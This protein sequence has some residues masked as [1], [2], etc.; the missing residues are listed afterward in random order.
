MSPLHAASTVAG[1][2]LAVGPFSQIQV[3]GHAEVVLVQGDRETVT[4]EG[5]S[6]DPAHIRVRSNNGRLRIDAESDHGWF[7]LSGRVPTI[8]V[9]FR[10]LDAL[11]MS[12][13]VKVSA[14]AIDTPTLKVSAAGAAS[15]KIDQ[16]KTSELRFTGAGAAKSEIGGSATTQQIVISG[17]GSYRAAKLVSD[18]VKAIVS[19]AGR[20]VVNAQKDLS[21]T[22]S[23]AGAIDYLGDPAVKQR[24]SGAG[25]ITRRSAEAIPTQR[26]TQFVA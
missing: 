3:S 6:N 13:T 26:R 17:V 20:V 18:S 15:L 5:S 21:A 16:L 25:K 8:T 2:P 19:G 1:E 12:G 22:I 9:H 7:S 10:K 23:G 24:I 11:G 14:A 4:V